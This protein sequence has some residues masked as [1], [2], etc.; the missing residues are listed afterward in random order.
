MNRHLDHDAFRPIGD[1]APSAIEQE[2][3]KGMADEILTLRIPLSDPMRIANGLAERGFISAII[4][5]HLDAAI[6]LAR[7]EHVRQA[8]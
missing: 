3:I 2:I 1:I 7:D 8:T 6:A 4:T 5:P